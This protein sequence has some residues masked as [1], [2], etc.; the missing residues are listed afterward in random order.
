VDKLYFFIVNYS[1][2][3]IAATRV[4]SQVIHCKIY[5]EKVLP[6]ITILSSYRN[7]FLVVR[8]RYLVNTCKEKHIGL[9]SAHPA[10]IAGLEIS[11]PIS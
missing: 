9:N 5:C 3:K 10:S 6:P 2:L 11:C 7:Y 4:L 1:L 8:K